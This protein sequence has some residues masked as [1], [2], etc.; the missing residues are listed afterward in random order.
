[1]GA[2]DAIM[3]ATD[4]AYRSYLSI[5][6]D[7]REKE[8]EREGA[9]VSAL[10]G[11]VKHESQG[12]PEDLALAQSFGVPLGCGAFRIGDVHERVTQSDH[13][14]PHLDTFLRTA[15]SQLDRDHDRFARPGSAN[16][17]ARKAN[18]TLYRKSIKD[19]L[20]R[21]MLTAGR[22]H[23]QVHHA[24]DTEVIGKLH[25]VFQEM[26]EQSAGYAVAVSAWFDASEASDEQSSSRLLADLDCNGWPQSG[27]YAALREIRRAWATHLCGDQHLAVVVKHGID[28]WGDGPYAFTSPALVNT[29]YGRW[30][31]PEDCGLVMP[32]VVAVLV[33]RGCATWTASAPLRPAS[34]ARLFTAAHART[35]P[36]ALSICVIVPQ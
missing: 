29:I 35:R 23:R 9:V 12:L 22:A 34:L 7:G 18:A 10:F 6:T 5:F 11:L 28:S 31:H 8:I 33:A 25:A 17:A 2:A 13:P 32:V 24:E 27:R 19:A 20:A 36:T 4:A 30:W 15:I 14:A 16:D 1:M 3:E 26:E 21:G